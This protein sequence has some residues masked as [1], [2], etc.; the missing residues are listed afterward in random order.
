MVDHAF[1]LRIGIGIIV[2]VTL[3]ILLLGAL[4]WSYRR[5]QFQ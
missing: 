5:G 1:G 3:A 4:F 2:L